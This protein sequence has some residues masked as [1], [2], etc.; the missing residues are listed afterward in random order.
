MRPI[1][2]EDQLPFLDFFAGSGLVSQGLKDYFHSV[3]A[4]DICPLKAK[5]YTENHRNHNF[6]L[7][8]IEDLKGTELPNAALAWASFPCQDLSLAGKLLGI[9]GSRSGLVWEWLRVLD[10]MPT[11]PPVLVAEN[12]VGLVTSAGGE[13]FRLLYRAL[14]ERGYLAGAMVLDAEKWV[15]QSRPRVFVVAVAESISVEDFSS[16][17]PSWNHPIAIQKA[18]TGCEDGIW[19]KLPLPNSRKKGLSDI[20]DFDA[21]CDD[22]RRSLKNVSMIPKVHLERLLQKGLRV[23]P[24]YKRTRNGKQV[25]ELR[26]DDVAGCLRTPKGGSSR[27]FLVIPR[28]DRIDT[29]LLTIRETALLMGTPMTYRLPGVTDSFN[30]SGSYNEGYKAMG[31]AVAVPVSEHLAK[32]L[33]A[34]LAMRATNGFTLREA[35]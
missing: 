29:R 10:E 14:R 5:V 6:S 34:P 11:K 18:M 7:G 3:W 30:L 17:G 12:V 21:P 13:H 33:L 1:S 28:E 23:A 8:S 4:N 26:F 35:I 9:G 31:D 22:L 15:P 16:D 19:W 24:G 32:Y 20:V 2:R 25:L 27:Q